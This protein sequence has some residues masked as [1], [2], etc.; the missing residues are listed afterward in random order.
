MRD[1]ELHQLQHTL[2][3]G[4]WMSFDFDDLHPVFHPEHSDQILKSLSS[5]WNWILA[6]LDLPVLYLRGGSIIPL[7]LPYQHVGEANLTDDLSLLVALDEHGKAEGVLFEDDG[8]GY[9]YTKGGYLLTTYAAELQPSVVT[10]RVSKVEGTWKR[11]KRRLHMQLLLGKGAVLDAW[12][13]DGEVLQIMMP[14]ENEVSSLVSASEKQQKIRLESAKPIPDVENVSGHK[15][16]ELSKA[17]IEMKSGDWVL[18][19]V[20][21]VGGRIISMEHLPSGNAFESLRA[22]TEKDLDY[23]FS[24]SIRHLS[25]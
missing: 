24:F 2:P 13:T 11:P 6:L 23:L 7:G 17:P 20:P 10:L 19:L 8:D 16:T 4:I 15:G 9:D 21:W 1:Q 3:K 14:S 25:F 22:S 18:K 5:V 12:G